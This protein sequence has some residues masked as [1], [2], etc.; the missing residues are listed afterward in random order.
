MHCV[1]KY[2]AKKYSTAKI[3]KKALCIQFI[4]YH[5]ISVS[6]IM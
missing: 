4:N 2:N 5:N 1:N 3:K 6:D